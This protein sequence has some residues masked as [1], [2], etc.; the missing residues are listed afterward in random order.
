V[1]AT[2]LG[3]VA[4]GEALAF[5]SPPGDI[6]LSIGYALLWLLLIY[7][8][9]RLIIRLAYS[10]FRLLVALVFGPV[11]IILWAIPQTE[12]ITGL[13]LRELVGW[14]TTP[15]LVT[16]CLAMAIP[17]AS[18]RSGFLAAAAFGIAGLQ[19][20]YDLAGLLA[21][22]HAWGGSLIPRVSAR[23]AAGAVT[24]GGAGAV[25]AAVPANRMTTLADQYGYQ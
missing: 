13:W 10:L 4:I 3:Q 14:A 21:F 23:G 1:A 5:P 7:Y 16:A 15:L 11:A 9:V 20:A 8:G 12:W 25:A 18:G 19:A 22:G 2:G 6:A 17:L 24:G